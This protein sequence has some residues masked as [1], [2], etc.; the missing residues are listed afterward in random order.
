M[1]NKKDNNN[2][3]RV[4]KTVKINGQIQHVR[5]YRIRGQKKIKVYTVRD[6][7]F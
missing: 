4:T 1:P 5:A 3:H 2:V 7:K 6:V